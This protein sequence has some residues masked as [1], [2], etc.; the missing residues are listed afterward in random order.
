M[1]MNGLI[2]R[3][4]GKVLIKLLFP[5]SVWKNVLE[6]PSCVA[7]GRQGQLIASPL[8]LPNSLKYIFKIPENNF[9]T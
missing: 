8:E 3:R 1:A 2:F 9:F 4:F 7:R 6:T 5:F